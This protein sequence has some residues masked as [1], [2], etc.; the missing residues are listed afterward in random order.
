VSGRR[1][2]AAAWSPLVAK[3]VAEPVAGVVVCI[4]VPL[5]TE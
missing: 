2:S 4:S 3:S 1:L 5:E